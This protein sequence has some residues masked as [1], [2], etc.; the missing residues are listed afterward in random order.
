MTILTLRREHLYIIS[1]YFVR[2]AIMVE[3]RPDSRERATAITHDLD[4]VVQV[5]KVGSTFS[6][7]DLF[8]F[9]YASP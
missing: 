6:R 9:S 5:H 7:H 4:E 3:R 8:S 2:F 1:S